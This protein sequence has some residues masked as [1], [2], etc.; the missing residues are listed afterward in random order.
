[1]YCP[2]AGGEK[3]RMC[4][5]VGK[6]RCTVQRLVVGKAECH[7][8]LPRGLWWKKQDVMVY[9]QDVGGGKGNKMPWCT[10]QRL[11]VGKAGCHGVCMHNTVQRG[12]KGRISMSWC[13]V[14]R[15]QLEMGI[16]AGCPYVLSRGGV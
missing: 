1:M 13:T 10:V 12:G 7:G 9:C 15:L 11:E 14:Q 3:G 16:K 6:V 4:H 2:D 8:V 5:G